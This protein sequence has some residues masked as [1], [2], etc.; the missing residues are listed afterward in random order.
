MFR[1]YRFEHPKT[2]ESVVIHRS[3]YVA[4]GIFGPFYVLYMRIPGFFPSLLI[5]IALTAVIVAISGVTSFFLPPRTQ[6]LALVIAIPVAL[7]IQSILVI[8]LV[9]KSYRRRGWL[10]R[11]S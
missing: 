10:I 1:T 4:A 8:D 9:K 11:A 5:S 3:S 7:A 2:E 6:L